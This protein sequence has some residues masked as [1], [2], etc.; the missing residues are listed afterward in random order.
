MSLTEAIEIHAKALKYRFGGRAPE[1][2][3]QTADRCR[4]MNDH[5]GHAVWLRVAD[6][7]E[8]LLGAGLRRGGADR[9][10]LW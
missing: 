2:A 1:L 4:R 7:A 10:S 3:R 9:H 8:A 6:V 5:D